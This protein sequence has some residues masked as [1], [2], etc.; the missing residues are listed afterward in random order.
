MARMIQRRK[1]HRFRLD[2][3]GTEYPVRFKEDALAAEEP[4]EIPINGSSFAVT[5]S[6]SSL[7]LEIP[8]SVPRPT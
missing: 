8:P 3:T 4:L 7:M 6:P 2:D 1:I 5:C